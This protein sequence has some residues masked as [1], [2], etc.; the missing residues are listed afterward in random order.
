MLLG[1]EA[2]QPGSQ[3]ASSDG[4]LG[5]SLR[6]SEASGSG[7]PPAM[8]GP[9]NVSFASWQH[10]RESSQGT[11]SPAAVAAG[12]LGAVARAAAAGGA[13]R[14]GGGE[15]NV[16]LGQQA[17][18]SAD[19]EAD[20]QAE[21]S[22]PAPFPR[23]QQ[24]QQAW[25]GA[26]SNGNGFYVPGPPVGQFPA[27]GDAGV[28]GAEPLENGNHS[29]M[30]EQQQQQQPGEEQQQQALESQASAS[31]DA[32]PNK[33]PF[34]SGADAPAAPTGAAGA[35]EWGAAEGGGY[36]WE[37]AREWGQQQQP[38]QQQYPGYA[39]GDQQQQDPLGSGALPADA[40]GGQQQ[41]GWEGGAGWGVGAEAGTGGA[42]DP[43]GGAAADSSA[44]AGAEGAAAWQ[45]PAADGTWQQQQ[46][47]ADG[48]QG[49]YAGYSEQQ[50]YPGWEQQQQ[51]DASGAVD[52]SGFYQPQPPQQQDAAAAAGAYGGFYQPTPAGSAG[53]QQ[54]P[55]AGMLEP[56]HP[57][58]PGISIA[59]QDSG[60][61]TSPTYPPPGSSG[62]RGTSGS[63]KR[64]SMPGASPTAGGQGGLGALLPQPPRQSM[65]GLS[66]S[67]SLDRQGEAAAVIL[68]TPAAAGDASM[69][70][71]FRPSSPYARA[72]SPL[73]RTSTGVGVEGQQTN[74]QSGGGFPIP[75]PPSHGGLLSNRA[76]SGNMFIPGSM[77]AG[78]AAAAAAAAVPA[79][80][81]PSAAAV[82]AGASPTS[83]YGQQQHPQQ[84]Q[85]DHAGL[86][87]GYDAAPGMP[88]QEHG[89]QDQQQQ[90]YAGAV[91]QQE[92]HQQQQQPGAQFGA[93]GPPVPPFVPG[94][95]ESLPRDAPPSSHSKRDGSSQQQ[96]QPF[97][98]VQAGAAAGG[99]RPAERA[100]PYDQFLSQALS[101][102]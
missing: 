85:P 30:D 97:V 91:G 68:S 3:Q 59:A 70:T 64:S 101:Q 4:G 84:Y 79:P 45:Q 35:A 53:E 23:K 24:Q 46:P 11:G 87:N 92:Q 54:Q 49:Y 62:S 90:A 74:Q 25:P 58:L 50:Q 44:F 94:L 21:V 9:S 5:F 52:V 69:L 41:G 67:Q 31:W 78:A 27:A 48:Q 13:E 34:D 12:G 19:M 77:P 93:Q 96:Q 95:L 89:P 18:S 55:A 102:V 15:D 51:Y 72:V 43:E 7:R 8:S 57:Q 80:W 28:A 14:A 20:A 2:A 56:V 65:P 66:P 81:Q 82:T 22:S 26:D 29:A 99:K 98:P 10:L 6:E 100:H 88:W 42:A 32:R 38:Q 63:R 60:G 86:M 33:D 39:Y 40:E 47:A 71:T 1:S 76:P 73:S 61:V 83:Q 37:G 16:L 75:S 17:S 36:G